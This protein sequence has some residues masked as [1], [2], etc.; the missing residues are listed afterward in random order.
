MFAFHTQILT[1][2]TLKLQ[3]QLLLAILFKKSM[4]QGSLLT[5]FFHLS[6][7][8]L[9]LLRVA[10]KPSPPSV[11]QLVLSIVQKIFNFYSITARARV[12][13]APILVACS[14]G[15]FWWGEWIY[16]SIGC[17]GRHLDIVESWGEVKNLPSVGERKKN[18]L[19]F[20]PQFSQ[21]AVNPK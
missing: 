4:N 7:K 20:S 10:H 5:F 16:I 6:D 2:F 8:F 3:F 12:L 19:S 14:A 21:S 13:V 1:K 15:G 11:K 18:S 9:L 17:S